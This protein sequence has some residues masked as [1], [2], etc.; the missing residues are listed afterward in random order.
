MAEEAEVGCA[1]PTGGPVGEEPSNENNEQQ[2][3]RRE[4]RKMK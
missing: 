2:S 1:R 3:V 4:A